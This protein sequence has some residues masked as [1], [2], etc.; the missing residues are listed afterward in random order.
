MRNRKESAPALVFA[1]V[2]DYN[3]N[4]TKRAEGADYENRYPDGGYLRESSVR[5]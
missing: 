5:V 1:P 4:R 2:W 3:G